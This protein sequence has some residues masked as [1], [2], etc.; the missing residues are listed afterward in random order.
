MKDLL[1][2]S[3]TQK[4]N[5]GDSQPEFQGS[6]EDNQSE[7]GDDDE[8]EEPDAVSVEVRGNDSG[9]ESEGDLDGEPL[10]DA[11]DSGDAAGHAGR[12]IQQALR[13]EEG[14]VVQAGESDNDSLVAQTEILG[15]TPPESPESSSSVSVDMRDSQVG[16]S[17]LSAFYQKYGNLGRDDEW[18]SKHRP[19]PLCVINGDK[20]GMLQHI[21]H[22]LTAGNDLGK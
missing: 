17:W 13:V 14:Q 5:R 16:T 12:V 10:S 21:K 3:P 20:E 4:R 7:V 9:G 18:R 1:Q 11:G 22:T 6:D 8:S 19:G 15:A 2:D